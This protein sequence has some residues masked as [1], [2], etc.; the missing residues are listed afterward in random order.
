METE[1][2]ALR[3][4]SAGDLNALKLI[5]Q[6]DEVMYAYNGAF[7]DEEVGGWLDKQLRNYAAWG[8]GLWAVTLR[9]SGEMIGQCGLTR[10]AWLGSEVL[11][12][13]Y[14]FRRSHWHKGYAAEAARACMDYAF[15]R[16]GATEVCSIIRDNNLLSQ[17]VALRNGMERASGVMVKH[18][19]GVDM[20]HWLYVKKRDWTIGR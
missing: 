4:M 8:Y 1:R 15:A 6:D 11:E 19:R 3:E 2:L 12:V 14:L 13:G 5:L 20:P 17:R 16:L 10:Q 18:Y 9:D 7:S